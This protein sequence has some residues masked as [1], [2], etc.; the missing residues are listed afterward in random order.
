MNGVKASTKDCIKNGDTIDLLPGR[1]GTNAIANI[2]DLVEDMMA[3]NAT[4]D[5]VAVQ[6]EPLIHINGILKSID[7]SDPRP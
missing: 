3:I 6:L 4:M 2:S 7:T 5:G 1:D